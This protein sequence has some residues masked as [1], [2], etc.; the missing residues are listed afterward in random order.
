[1]QCSRLPTEVVHPPV[2]EGYRIQMHKALS[3]GVIPELTLPQSGGPLW[4]LSMSFPSCYDPLKGQQRLA[5]VYT[6]HKFTAV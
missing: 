4:D 1:M 3:T 6:S 2:L 5:K